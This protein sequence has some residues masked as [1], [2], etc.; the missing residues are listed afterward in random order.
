MLREQPVGGWVITT[1]APATTPV[2]LSK[3]VPRIAVSTVCAATP[4]IPTK[5]TTIKQTNLLK[6]LIMFLLFSLDA[7][8]A[9]P[10]CKASIVSTRQPVRIRDGEG[11]RFL[12]FHLKRPG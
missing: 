2:P 9:V 8:I 6:R 11:E 1:V 10:A 7:A 4:P 3:T 12:P 5:A